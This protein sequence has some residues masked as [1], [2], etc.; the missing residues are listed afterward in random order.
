MKIAGLVSCVDYSDLLARGIDG[1][2]NGLDSLLVVTSSEDG[3]TAALCARA[4]VDLY[5]TDAFKADGAVFNKAKALDEALGVLAPA[6]WVLF[7]DADVV[8]PPDWRE[9]VESAAPTAGNLY[10]STRREESGAPILEEEL[11]GCFHL[12]HVADPV[13]QDRP[14]L[15]SWVSAGSYDSAF[16]MRWPA[17]RRKLLRLDLTHLGAM[18]RNWCGRGN[19]AGMTRL[20]AERQRRG[21]WKHE[22][23]DRVQP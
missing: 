21:G 2:R 22:R 12:W 6:D 20:F 15:G 16:W 8:P 3:P 4:G 19:V 10:G 23:L 17:D 18:G 14:L 11:A 5:A 1:W 9:R 13:A 7:F